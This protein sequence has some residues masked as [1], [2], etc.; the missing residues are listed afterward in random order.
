ML[1]FEKVLEVFKDFLAEGIYEIVTTS[2]GLTVL[3]WDD[4]CKDWTSVKLCRTPQEL[5]DVLLFGYT[6]NLKYKATLARRELTEGDL[7]QVNAQRKMIL[8]KLQP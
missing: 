7:A 3:E 8:E 6:G 2:H 5:A 1:T 4:C